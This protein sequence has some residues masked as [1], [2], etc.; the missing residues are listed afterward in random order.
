MDYI[1]NSLKGIAHRALIINI[2]SICVKYMKLIAKF[3]IAALILWWLF[4][5]KRINFEILI[6][7]NRSYLKWILYAISILPFQIIVVSI[8]WH[9]LQKVRNFSLSLYESIQLTFIA[10]FFSTCL[11][12]SMGGD[13]VKA[14]MVIKDSPVR[15]VEAGTIILLDRLIGIF[16]LILLAF[17]ASI[18]MIIISPSRIF[19]FK[20]GLSL[21]VILGLTFLISFFFFNTCAIYNV[22]LLEKLRGKFRI[23]KMINRI[24]FEIRAFKKHYW[25][26]WNAIILSFIGHGLVI[27]SYYLV[28]RALNDTIGLL[29]YLTF[30][31]IV[32]VSNVL[33]LTP[34]GIGVAESVSSFLWK[35]S[36]TMA[37]GNIMLIFRILLFIVGFVFGIPSWLLWKM[38]KA[39][40]SKGSNL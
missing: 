18:I 33:P 1:I 29:K 34:G 37:G 28:G 24:Y 36:G 20:L 26:L 39:K 5:T 2:K 22:S 30:T 13:V 15:K 35:T 38:S 23:F 31:P 19:F 27:I 11:P 14:M 25:I 4:V 17:I 6:N 9:Q 12:G 10:V 3:L 8:R 7:L 21:A 32:I 16:S 40:K